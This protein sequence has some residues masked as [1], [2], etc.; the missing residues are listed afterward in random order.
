MYKN[1]YVIGVFDLFHRGHVEL[2]KKA[3]SLGQN[4]IVAVNSDVKVTGY[5]KKPVFS[6]TDRLEI[7]KSCRYVDKA[8]IINEYDQKKFIEKYAI[9]VIIHG[10]DWKR[11]RY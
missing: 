9:N 4:L 5:K 3:K 11:E 6:E 1:I 7:I 2:L 8:F 10:S